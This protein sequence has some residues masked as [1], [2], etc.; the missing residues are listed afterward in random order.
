M[1][2]ITLLLVFAALAATSCSLQLDSQYGLRWEPSVKTAPHEATQKPLQK[3]EALNVEPL[4]ATIQTNVPN[5][6]IEDFR[7]ENAPPLTE[8]FIDSVPASAPIPGAIPEELQQGTTAPEL[9]AVEP[10]KTSVNFIEF[11]LALAFFG[12]FLASLG[13]MGVIIGLTN[14]SGAGS[15]GTIL[16]T[17]SA[18]EGL[19]G[20]LAMGLVAVL[21]LVIIK[22]LIS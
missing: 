21:C 12:G 19:A 6:S 16:G 7:F 10:N 4:S 15:T 20:V 9:S 17:L 5:Y 8:N 14:W 3:I 2:N 22:G 1:R 13:A 18:G 11:I